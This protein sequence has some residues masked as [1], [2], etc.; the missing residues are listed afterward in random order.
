MSCGCGAPTFRLLDGIVGWDAASIKGI[1]GEW[2]ADGIRL[3]RHAGGADLPDAALWPYLPPPQLAY[4]C[5][6]CTW[7]LVTPR[8]PVS[9]LLLLGPCDACNARWPEAPQDTSALPSLAA[10]AAFAELIA[11]A[12]TDHDQV[13]IYSRSGPLIGALALPSPTHLAFVSSR[14]LLV[15]SGGRHIHRV[16]PSSV[17]LSRVPVPLADD[18]RITSMGVSGDRAIWIVV[19]ASAGGRQLRR[20]QEGR[21]WSDASL[22]ELRAAFADTGLVLVAGDGFA[23]RRPPRDPRG[24]ICV[25]SWYGR[26]ADVAPPVIS[27]DLFIRQGQLM[28]AAIDSGVPRC[29]WHRVRVVAD[30][31]VG[32]SLEIAV[33]AAESVAGVDP[34]GLAD[35]AW[36]GFDAGVPHPADWQAVTGSQDYLIN[37]PPG[38]FLHVRIR[39][40]SDGGAT[41]IVRQVRLD[42][43]RATSVDALPAVYR[44]D[45]RAEDFTERFVS[46]VDAALEDLDETVLRLPVLLDVERTPAEALPWMAR[47][48]GATLDPAWD[49]ARR[50]KILAALPSLY[51]VRGTLEGLARAVELVFDVRP[52]IEESGAMSMS[53]AVAALD[54][55]SPLDARLG[56]V[57]LF[58]RGRAR[59]R[60][61]ASALGRTPIRS[62]GDPSLDPLTQGAYRVRVSLPAIGAPAA[63]LLP[64]LRALV[65]SQKPAHVTASVRVGSGLATVGGEL[66]V[67]I[68]THLGLPPPRVI[69]AAGNFRL[70]RDAILRGA[71]R[72]GSVV[73]LTTTSSPC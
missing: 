62:Y 52:A 68:D 71:K 59:L 11:V 54:R 49:A 66:R 6:T 35:P 40:T 38:R 12:D 13:R 42:F 25:V 27:P 29:R 4:D 7:F 56:A 9:R 64:R 50:R 39:M 69:G 30:V 53:A 16:D 34:Q 10:V 31:P 70:R 28:T 23:V 43:P 15:V 3:D 18:A 32:T 57:R 36:P 33:A 51:Q 55:R 46:L 24:E 20:W 60:L 19:D 14:E 65:D 41:P 67:G 63:A 1:T 44:E 45:P 47:F 8:P 48:L 26:P 37:Q 2:D 72:Q 17:R 73:G 21:G 61:G 58:G 22:A 5:A